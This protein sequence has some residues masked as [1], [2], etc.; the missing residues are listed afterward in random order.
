LSD[1]TG[2]DW[3][4]ALRGAASETELIRCSA[5][6]TDQLRADASN[7]GFFAPLEKPVTS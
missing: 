3:L 4:A 5:L 2:L 7:F 6:L 1:I